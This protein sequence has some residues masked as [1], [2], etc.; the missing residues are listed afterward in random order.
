MTRL[1]LMASLTFAAGAC[2]AMPAPVPMSCPVVRSI[3]WQ[4]WVNAMPGPNMQ[5][6]LIA[7]GKVTVPTGGYSFRW[8]EPRVMESYPV[9]VSVELHPVPPAG[10]ATQAL[11]TH[12][13]RGEW[14]MRPPVGALTVTCGGRILGHVSPV[15]SAH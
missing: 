8:G 5:P 15:E 3:D 10:P 7:I 12:E 4:A 6:R 2:Q 9:Q 13:V 1:I 11:T 14:P